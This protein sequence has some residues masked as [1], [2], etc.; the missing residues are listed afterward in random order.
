MKRISLICIVFYLSLTSLQGQVYEVK[1][2]CMSKCD[3]AGDEKKHT[4]MIHSMM[5]NDTIEKIKEEKMRFPLRIAVIQKETDSIS[6]DEKTILKA[7][8]ELNV[9]FEEVGFVFYLERL[10]MIASDLFLEDLS[11]DL[12]RPYDQFS[13]EFDLPDMISV[14]VFDHKEEYCNVSNNSISCGRVGGFS[15]ILSN[16][17]NNLVL[18]KFDIRDPKIVAHEFG[19]FFGLYHTFEERQF[20][21]DDFNPSDCHMKGDRIC[22]TP[23]D[24]GTL[25]EVYINYSTCEMYD[26]K[27][28]N[29]IAYKPMIENYMS[30]YKPCYLRKYVFTKGQQEVMK[31]AGH[32]KLRSKFGR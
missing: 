28:E 21:K 24:P 2:W 15:Y 9:S 5:K 12:Y 20:G 22:D 14:F 27:N 16:L 26:L 31:M 17:T 18:S 25:F 19:H 10:D 4:E 29:G 30:Y 8:E 7:I 6:I 32:S 11:Q 3:L 13:K 1:N 23:P